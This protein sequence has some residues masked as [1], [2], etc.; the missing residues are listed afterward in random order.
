MKGESVDTTNITE[1]LELFDKRYW[2]AIKKKLH[3]L[4][5]NML[6]TNEK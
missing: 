3:W 1:I 5:M 6:G 4:I 2:A